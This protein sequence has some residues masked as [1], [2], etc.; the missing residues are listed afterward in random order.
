MSA[1]ANTF[2]LIT[3]LSSLFAIRCFNVHTRSTLEARRMVCK[4][5]QQYAFYL[6]DAANWLFIHV[7]YKPTTVSVTKLLT[8]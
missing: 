1:T 3:R 4:H 2:V 8:V 6:G 7:V 5:K